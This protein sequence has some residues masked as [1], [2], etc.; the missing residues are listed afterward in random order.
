M[1]MYW[2]EPQA[3][4]F[5]KHLIPR[6]QA[7]QA[8]ALA[9]SRRLPGRPHLDISHPVRWP[10]DL[11]VMPIEGPIALGSPMGAHMVLPMSLALSRPLLD[12]LLGVPPQLHAPAA[13]HGP[14]AAQGPL[15][16]PHLPP[17]P[18]HTSALGSLRIV[19]TLNIHAFRGQLYAVSNH[20]MPCTPLTAARAAGTVIAA[21]DALSGITPKPLR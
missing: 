21:G 17:A 14:A 4:I 2:T 15:A 18:V 1:F 11:L 10:I 7:A 6:S 9:G 12:G 16:A 13:A 20:A 3:V 8:A 19:D 5:S